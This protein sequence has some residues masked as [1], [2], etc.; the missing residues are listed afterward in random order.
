M[1]DIS[2]LGERRPSRQESQLPGS[3]PQAVVGGAS[4]HGLQ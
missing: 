3:L 1:A 4:E 2:H